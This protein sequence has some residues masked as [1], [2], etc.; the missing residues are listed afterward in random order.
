M[1]YGLLAVAVLANFLFPIHLL[2]HMG[3]AAR[4]VTAMVLLA[5]P[6]FFAALIF[7]RS[8]KETP[9]PEFAFASNVLGAVVGGLLEY[10]S[11]IL[12]FRNLLLLALA[13]YMFSYLALLRTGKTAAAVVT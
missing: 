8:F 13:L 7:A 6:L 3:L 5:T 2:L 9:A 4:L 10:G 11:I 1:L 12:G